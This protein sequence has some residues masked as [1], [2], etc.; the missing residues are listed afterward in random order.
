MNPNHLE[1]SRKS[2]F[3]NVLR[4][5]VTWPSL[6]MAIVSL[7]WQLLGYQSDSCAFVHLSNCPLL[8][9]RISSLN[10]FLVSF[11][12]GTGTF[13]IFSIFFLCQCETIT[14]A[15]QCNEDSLD[16]WRLCDGPNLPGTPFRIL[17]SSI[18]LISKEHPKNS[19]FL[20]NVRWNIDEQ[21]YYTALKKSLVYLRMFPYQLW[22]SLWSL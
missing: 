8:V 11:W 4:E 15:S 12:W 17:W 5:P 13:L 6:L 7:R 2:T 21:W 20:M 14:I 1:R 3:W 19:D 16:V 9:L 18:L 22:F 10:N